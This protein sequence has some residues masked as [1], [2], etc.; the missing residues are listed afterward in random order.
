MML[1]VRRSAAVL[2]MRRDHASIAVGQAGTVHCLFSAQELVKAGKG[3]L[4]YRR[5]F[6]WVQARLCEKRL[7]CGFC[8]N[9]GVG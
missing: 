2:L 3:A 8:R 9:N 7:T 4:Q 6:R 5:W 1:K